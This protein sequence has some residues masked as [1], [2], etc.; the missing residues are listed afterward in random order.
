MLIAGRDIKSAGATLQVSRSMNAP[1]KL[2]PCKALPVPSAALY[3]SLSY[4]FTSICQA[5]TAAFMCKHLDQGGNGS[6]LGTVLAA[7]G[8][9][10]SADLQQLCGSTQHT[11][12]LAI[13]V[14]MGLP[15]VVLLLLWNLAAAA[16]FRYSL[17]QMPPTSRL[18]ASTAP[19]ATAAASA[20]SGQVRKLWLESCV[21]RPAVQHLLNRRVFVA[22]GSLLGPAVRPAAWGW[23]CADLCGRLVL[24]VVVVA[25]SLTVHSAVQMLIIQI[26]VAM[27]QLW[28][29]L[30]QPEVVG[31]HKYINAL[32]HALLHSVCILSVVISS[33]SSASGIDWNG[34]AAAI[35]SGLWLCGCCVVCICAVVAACCKT[36]AIII[37][38]NIQ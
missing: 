36:A 38:Y 27:L 9:Y 26:A 1:L 29:L 20:D 33:G 25:T 31:W 8:S 24:A 30:C 3:C 2:V 23:C 7:T 10:W 37:S 16:S 14:L 21:S 5:T 19:A 28:H 17:L 32:W 18:V 13:S 22:V 4:C 34:Q 11:A 6:L 15:A 35:V 12:A